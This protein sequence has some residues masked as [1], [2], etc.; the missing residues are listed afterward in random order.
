MLR[1]SVFEIFI[2]KLLYDSTV[3][4]FVHHR[5]G[6]EWDSVKGIGF[7]HRINRHIFKIQSVT[8]PDL[9]IEGIFADYVARQAG[10]A[11]RR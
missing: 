10:I 6:W 2:S 7:Y 1:Q 9:G 3:S 11:E 8:V 5:D 4:S